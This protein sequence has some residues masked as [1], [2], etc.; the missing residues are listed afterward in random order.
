MSE[1]W[2]VSE[3]RPGYVVKE[4]KIGIHT[5]EIYRPILSQDDRAVTEKQV[6]A[7]LE[8]ATRAAAAYRKEQTA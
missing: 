2:T 5:V 3:K 8:R 4:L 6:M 7:E 1:K